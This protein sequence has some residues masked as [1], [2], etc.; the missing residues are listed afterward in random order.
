MINE[1]YEPGDIERRV[2]D[3]AKAMND[4]RASQANHD[5]AV[6]GLQY[7]KL[8]KLELLVDDLQGVINDIPRE[9]DQF[10]FA[11]TKGKSPR[12]WVDMTCFVRLVGEGHDYELVK[13]TR[14]GRS[15]LVRDAS[16]RRIGEHVTKYVAE[17]VLERERMLEGEWL[18]KSDLQKNAIHENDDTNQS[19]ISHLH[20]SETDESKQRTYNSRAAEIVNQPRYSALSLFVW[21]LLGL[22]GGGLILFAL[23]WFDLMDKIVG[24]AT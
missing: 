5:D 12:L 4:V 24:V 21:F 6:E 14:M 22:I 8:S 7:G 3:L 13:D 19:N 10:E 20:N 15:V 11:I 18:S 2:H 23:T 17:R 9:N 1:E 16:R